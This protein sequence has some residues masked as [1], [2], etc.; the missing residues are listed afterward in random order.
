MIASLPMYDRP[1]LTE[2]TDQFWTLVRDGLRKHGIAAP[3]ELSRI[4]LDVDHWLSPD[5]VFSQTCG[6]PFRKQLFG[7]VTLIGTPDY[8]LDGCPPG[9]YRSAIISKSGR[10]SNGLRDAD[11]MTLAINDHFS[12]SGNTA[13]KVSA[14]H[15]G[16]SI[17]AEL[18]TGAHVNSVAAILSGQADWAAI[19]A[20]TWR[21]IERYDDTSNLAV[22]GYSDPTP[23]TPY[24][25]GSGSDA[26][27]YFSVVATAIQALP[28]ESRSALGLRGLVRVPAEK[29]FSVEEA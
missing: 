22:L 27:L 1:E 9:F 16:L 10:F 6:L 3:D 21:L 25:A 4:A 17:G 2:H 13:A 23:A 26:D 7:H 29:Y 28:A 15:A 14:R 19:D 11:G 20:H 24:I 8:G 5:L 18:F 12:Q